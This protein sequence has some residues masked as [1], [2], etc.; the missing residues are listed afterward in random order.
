MA[1]ADVIPKLPT[2]FI[3]EDLIAKVEQ[4]QLRIFEHIESLNEKQPAELKSRSL[5]L[6]DPYGNPLVSTYV[7]HELLGTVIKKFKQQYVPKYLQ[8]W[9]AYGTVHENT[10]LPLCD[11][12]LKSTVSESPDGRQLVAHGE[13]SIWTGYQEDCLLRKIL[14]RVRLTDTMEKIKE[15]LNESRRFASIELKSCVRNSH[16]NPTVENWNEGTTLEANDTVLACH[17]Y[18]DGRVLMAKLTKV[19]VTNHLFLL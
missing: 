19:E 9:I 11:T 2:S 15:R 7:D 5:T 14:L 13:I 12:D 3:Y 17:L 18:Q 4:I 16:D 10:I 1:A 6:L 8:Q